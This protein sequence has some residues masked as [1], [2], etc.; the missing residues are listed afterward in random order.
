MIIVI[1][2]GYKV[3]IICITSSC[4]H[5]FTTVNVREGEPVLLNARAVGTPT[6]RISWQKDGVPLQ[7]SPDVRVAIDGGATTLDIPR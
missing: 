6:P 3:I 2:M 5:R 1:T 7:A 4:I